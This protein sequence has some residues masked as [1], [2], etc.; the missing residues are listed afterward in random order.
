[1]R[2]LGLSLS[3]TA[4]RQETLSPWPARGRAR[5][6]RRN[7]TQTPSA[8]LVEMIRSN[9]ARRRPHSP[10]PRFARRRAGLQPGARALGRELPDHRTDLVHHAG[11]VSEL[12][13]TGQGQHVL[14]DACSLSCADYGSKRA[15]RTTMK[16]VGVSP[17]IR[18][19]LTGQSPTRTSL[20]TATESDPLGAPDS[21]PGPYSHDATGFDS[22]RSRTQINPFGTALAASRHT[23]SRHSDG[24]RTS[25]SSRPSQC[26]TVTAVTGIP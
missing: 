21:T 26:V 25:V 4:A 9:P 24:Y 1:M 14:R 3:Q 5:P 18:R 10:R 11:V 15:A 7:R 13:C 19:S 2:L 23:R 12:T 20:S 16:T 6:R 8:E 17:S 22:A